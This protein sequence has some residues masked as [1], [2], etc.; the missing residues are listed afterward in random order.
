VV[1]KSNTIPFF[2]GIGIG[3]GVGAAVGEAIEPE[4]TDDP[5]LTAVILGCS[6]P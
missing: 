5:G 2:I 1:K 6:E 3:I 4:G